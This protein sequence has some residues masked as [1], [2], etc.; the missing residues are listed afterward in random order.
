MSGVQR[1]DGVALAGLL[2]LKQHGGDKNMTV[3][4][5]DDSGVHWAVLNEAAE[6]ISA[7]YTAREEAWREQH[8]RDSAELRSLCEQRDLA[9][10][11][12]EVYKKGYADASNRAQAAE[13][14]ALAAEAMLRELRKLTDALA[15]P[16]QIPDD[17]DLALLER[18]DAALREGDPHAK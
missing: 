6:K 8:G 12:R 2:Y 1:W 7:D 13:A 16:F 11:E 15:R 10:K 9:R 17:A 3:G 4:M 14:R 18:I 5:F